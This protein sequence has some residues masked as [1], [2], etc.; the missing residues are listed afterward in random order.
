M[1]VLSSLMDPDG[2]SGCAQIADLIVPALFG[3]LPGQPPTVLET[4]FQFQGISAPKSHSV[5][6]GLTEILN[7][8][9]GYYTWEFG[10]LK[11]GIR[12]NGAATEAFTRGNML[13]QSMTLT[14]IQAEFREVN[15]GLC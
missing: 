1:F 10:R 2:V 13:Y 6:W 9:L 7:S 3:N 11:L 12:E 5:I 15:H 8:A 14:E 4:Q